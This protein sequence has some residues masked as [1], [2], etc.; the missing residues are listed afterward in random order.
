[1]SCT[2]PTLHEGVGPV[3]AG[4]ESYDGELTHLKTHLVY[5]MCGSS[6]RLLVA[7]LVRVK[8]ARPVACAESEFTL[9]GPALTFMFSPHHW[10]L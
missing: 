5:K 7:C 6:R 1:M 4:L 2:T 3:L 8:G 10:V 9:A